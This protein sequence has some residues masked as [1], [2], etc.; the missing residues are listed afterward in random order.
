M[1]PNRHQNDHFKI[2]C[3]MLRCVTPCVGILLILSFDIFNFWIN[4]H[5]ILMIQTLA[6]HKLKFEKKYIEEYTVVG[7]RLPCFSEYHVL[8]NPIP[9]LCISNNTQIKTKITLGLTNAPKR[10]KNKSY[11]MSVIFSPYVVVA[12]PWFIAPLGYDP[13]YI[14]SYKVHLCRP[15]DRM[16][17]G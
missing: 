6:N 8:S 17:Q 7:C 13:L 2:L 3:K 5:V 12:V 14:T 16:W 1:V 4:V 15:P 11:V 10:E 9:H